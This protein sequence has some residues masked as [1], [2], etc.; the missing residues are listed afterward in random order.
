MITLIY[1]ARGNCTNNCLLII[2]GVTLAAVC[3]YNQLLSSFENIRKM[4][5]LKLNNRNQ[6]EKN[7]TKALVDEN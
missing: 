3:S 5:K 7:T 2:E 6:N 1:K 4:I